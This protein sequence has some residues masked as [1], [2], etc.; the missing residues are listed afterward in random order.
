MRIS[1][2]GEYAAKAV[3]YLSLKYPQMA[4]I[5]EI[6]E[7]HSIPVKY[8]EHIL[9]TLKRAG[10]LESRRGARGGYLLSRPPDQISVG[11]VL[12]AVDGKFSQ[13]SCIEVSL[14]EHYSCPES[15]ACGLKQLWQDVQGA[16]EKIL[17]HT[18]FDEIRKRTLSGMV[19]QSPYRLYEI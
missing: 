8:L 14:R 15:Q 6:A 12:K 17:F 1:A 3:L 11:H 2:K 4:T 7:S 13:A 9:L 18:S 19:D 5:H 16:V 10:F